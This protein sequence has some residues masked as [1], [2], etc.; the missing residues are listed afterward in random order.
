[1]F[2]IQKKVMSHA[3]NKNMWSIKN[4]V[5]RKCHQ[6]SFDL[7]LNKLCCA[8]LSCSVMSD[9]ATPWI[10]AYQAPLSM[11]ILQA[12]I[13]EWVA[14]SFS[15]GSSWPRN[16]TH[17]SCIADGF[18]TVEPPGKPQVYFRTMYLFSFLNEWKILNYVALCSF[19]IFHAGDFTIDFI[20]SIIKC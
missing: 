9:S 13:L 6:L 20:W 19:P 14:I 17:I 3:R 7:A 10:V 12:K 16:R 5:N 1:M 8:V 4:A 11:R 15:R 2:R 18:F